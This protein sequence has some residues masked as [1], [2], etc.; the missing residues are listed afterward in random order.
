M[1]V[2]DGENRTRN[3][4]MSD[5]AVI[6]GTGHQGLGLVLR[7]AVAGFDV[8]IGSRDE[9][10]ART[11]ADDALARAKTFRPAAQVTGLQNSD[12]AAAAPVVVLCVPIMAH[13]ETIRG[14]KDTLSD[15]ALL[16]DVTV[17]LAAPLGIRGGRLLGLPAGS[18]AEQA[19]ELAP[20]ATRVAA[21]FHLLAAEALQDLAQPVDCDA[22]VCGDRAARERLRPFA[23]AIPGVRY[24]DGGPL[25]NARLIESSAALVIGMNGRYKVRRSGLRITGLP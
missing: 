25:Y 4:V 18:A 19:A 1:L 23:E 14:F 22:I 8:T 6:G 16:V 5:V 7:W 20:P 17:P 10:R 15:D 11:A 24:V 13:A 21:A 3:D 2:A 12:A 9:G